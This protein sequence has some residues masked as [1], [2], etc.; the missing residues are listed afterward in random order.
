LLLGLDS[1]WFGFV[2]VHWWFQNVSKH[3][4]KARHLFGIQETVAMSAIYIHA[5]AVAGG[6]NELKSVLLQLMHPM[7]PGGSAGPG[8]V[9]WVVGDHRGP[10]DESTL[11]TICLPQTKALLPRNNTNRGNLHVFCLV[12][13]IVFHL[14]I[15]RMR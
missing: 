13:S 7:K 5:G 6:I 3:I 8:R 9:G 1:D 12:V 14:V 2:S 15:Q 11:Y 4:P 10:M